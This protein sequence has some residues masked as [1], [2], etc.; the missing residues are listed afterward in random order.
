MCSPETGFLLCYLNNHPSPVEFM[1]PGV[2]LL[3]ALA[4]ELLH[5]V[6]LWTRP[7]LASVDV[8][9]VSV[10]FRLMIHHLSLHIGLQP[11]T[12]SGSR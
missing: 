11:D 2:M 3:K 4:W 6:L 1:V 12:V 5:H 10:L 9:H 8:W 7:V